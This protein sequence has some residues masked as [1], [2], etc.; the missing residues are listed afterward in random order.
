MYYKR[1]QSKL[2]TRRWITEVIMENNEGRTR[3]RRSAAAATG[4]F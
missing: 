1:H 3:D 4:K 2:I